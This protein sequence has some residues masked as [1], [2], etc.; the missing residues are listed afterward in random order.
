[1]KMTNNTKDIAL[2]ETS[3]TITLIEKILTKALE[4]GLPNLKQKIDHI[5]A[6]AGDDAA[7]ETLN[8]I[9]ATLTQSL[10]FEELLAKISV[11][12]DYLNKVLKRSYYHKN[13][14]DKLV[15][16]QGENFK[17]RLHVF[18][19]ADRST[20]MENIHDHRWHFASSIL[21]GQFGMELFQEQE[22]GE[23]QRFA[24]TYHPALDK[25]DSYSVEER[26]KVQLG[27]IANHTL[28]AGMQ[29]FLHREALHKITS[30]GKE[31]CVTL[32][33]TAAGQKPTCKL[34]AAKPFEQEEVHMERFTEAQLLNRF[35]WL[36]NKL[37]DHQIAS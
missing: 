26:G 30:M 9:I 6:F 37:N 22:G 28:V 29:Y 17:L 24:Y 18:H 11:S 1:M 5:I 32:M 25:K 23:E 19:P 21:Y 12:Q 7:E 13:G 20:A 34:Y 16:L 35:N 36:T 2:F 3:Q 14:F 33:L 8:T 10:L 15:L 4:E 27:C 31:G